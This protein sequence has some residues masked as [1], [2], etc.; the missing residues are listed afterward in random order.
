MNYY[1]FFHI[2][3]S[4]S[5]IEKKD[6][7]NVIDSCYYPLLDLI[8]KNNFKI[9][10]EASGNSLIEIEKLDKNWIEKLKTLIKKNKVEFIGSGYSQSIFPLVPYEINYKNIK[11]GNDIYKKILGQKPNIALVNEQVF[12]SSLIP[13]YKKNGYDTI[14]IDWKNTKLANKNLPNE[15]EF[16]CQRVYHDRKNSIKV[17]WSNSLLFQKFQNYVHG[18]ISKKNYLKFLNVRKS[19]KKN[20]CLYSNDAEVFNYRPGRFNTEAKLDNTDEWSVINNLY[21]SLD[22]KKNSFLFPSQ[23]VEKS[24]INKK[25]IITNAKH[26][27]VTKKQAKY[28]IMRWSLSGRDNL[29]IN[30]LCYRIYAHFRKNKISNKKNWQKLICFWSSD[31]RTH[32]TKKRWKNYLRE[33]NEFSNKIKLS[34]NKIDKKK[35]NILNINYINKKK[36]KIIKQNNLLLIADKDIEINLNLIKGM[37]IESYTDYKI[38]NKPIVGRIEKGFF[39][40]IN[41]DVDFFS[42]FSQ[43]NNTS[44][45]KKITEISER[46]QNV[47]IFEDDFL[48]VSKKFNFGRFVL[49]KTFIFDLKN[50]KFA[51]QNH[52]LNV[53]IGFLRFN[54]LTLNPNNFD[55]KKLYFETNN[56]GKL[57]DKFYLNNSEF[58]YGEHVSSICSATTGLGM[59]EEILKIGDGTKKILIKN[60][61]SIS[62]LV[63]MISFKKINRK[64]LFR[65]YQSGMEY[66]DTTMPKKKEIIKTLTWFSIL[67]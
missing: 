43:L 2:N 41:Y 10:V 25:I 14:I 12:S 28:N 29:Y 55:F 48:Y 30:T 21:K 51:I 40:H 49:D 59:T 39:N 61:N 45:N 44:S 35:K 26:P 15:L 37:S 20:L 52:F 54:Y 53:P 34:K 4:F 58:D 60:D 23:I 32:L 66:N 11:L 8:E 6:L 1:S 16:E 62:N 31:F 9:G 13:I 63:G 3:T 64:N 38:S 56:G 19:S 5:S 65:F 47:K 46:V 36:Y 7:K 24:K 18:E 67:S 22:I 57:T 17:L 50:K 27:I 33:I 42:G